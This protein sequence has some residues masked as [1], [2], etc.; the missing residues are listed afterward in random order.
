MTLQLILKLVKRNFIALKS[1]FIPFVVTASIMLG[2]E[3]IITSIINNDYI[4]ERH[5]D[6]PSLLKFVNAI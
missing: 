1:L 2:L 3:Y 6:L 5:K 4:L